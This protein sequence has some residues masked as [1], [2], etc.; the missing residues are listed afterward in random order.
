MSTTA[1][2]TA[3]L[4]QT[5]GP[6]VLPG[7]PVV[8]GV[9]LGP[10]VRPSGAVLLPADEGTVV[11]EGRRAGEKERFVAAAGAVADR[12]TERAAGATGVSAEVL[13]TTAGLARDRGL[14]SAVE[15]RIDAGTPAAVATVEAAQQFVDLF[16]SL[17]GLMAERVTDV[18]DVRDRIVAEL[19]GQGEPG[20]PRPEVPSVLL[21]EDLAPADTAGL[22]PARVIGLATR[23]GGTTSHT[24]IIARQL[25]L[26]CVVAV[27]GLDDVPVGATVL[28]DGERGTVTVD[29]DPD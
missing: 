2:G 18:R 12:L 27:G 26:P 14:L 22:D 5:G 24:A 20:V 8:P 28:L 25:G 1:P 6:V 17:G 11:P 3:A 23:L 16:T 19:T 7:T 21:A 15:Q 29:P 9:V 4:P 13:A 10:V